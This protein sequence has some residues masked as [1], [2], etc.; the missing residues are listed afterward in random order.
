MRR[1]VVSLAVLALVGFMPADRAAADNDHR[2]RAVPHTFVGTAPGCAPTPP[3]SHIVTAAWLSGM[4]LPDNDGPNTN[5]TPEQRADRRSGLLLSKNGL[6]TDCSSASAEIKGV[7][8]MEVTATFEL[9]F[10]YR[11]GGHCGAGS[12]RFNVTVRNAGVETSHFVGGCANDTSP[13]PAPQDT[14]QWTRVR[15][16]TASAAEAFP[17]LPVGSRIVSIELIVD[18][19]TDSVSTQDPMGVGL[20]V[21]DN[22]FI[23]GKFIRSGNNNR[24]RHDDEDED[25]GD[26]D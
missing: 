3:G 14:A 19:G 10:D 4:G 9:G 12:P 8:G 7:R 18:E 16:Q 25:E 15:F 22:I 17:P 6:T 5:T 21:V 13:T 11:N 20:S 1:L 26:E 2:L 24:D 23:N